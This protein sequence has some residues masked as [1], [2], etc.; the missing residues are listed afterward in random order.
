MELMYSGR[1][2]SYSQILDLAVK[3]SQWQTLK[4][5]WQK[6]KLFIVH[7]W[8]NFLQ[9]FLSLKLRTNK[10][11]F[12]YLT[13][14]FSLVF[15]SRDRQSGKAYQILILTHDKLSS[16]SI[17]YVSKN[18]FPLPLWI[19]TSWLIYLSLEDLHSL[20]KYCLGKLKT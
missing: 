4:C 7:F 9:T 8:S 10:Q 13:R 20:V 5:L 16:L 19:Q 2:W 14:L 11:D 12:L 6:Y 15:E 3:T 1:H 18:G 17:L